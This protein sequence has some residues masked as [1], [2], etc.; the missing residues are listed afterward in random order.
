MQVTVT[1]VSGPN[2]SISGAAEYAVSVSVAQTVS[3]QIAAVGVQG[4]P[5]PA[6][7]IGDIDLGTFN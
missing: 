4:P 1:S 5:G 2:L 3:V 6:A 7:Q